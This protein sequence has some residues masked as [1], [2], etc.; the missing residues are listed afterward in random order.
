L[1]LDDCATGRLVASLTLSGSDPP[2]EVELRSMARKS[3]RGRKEIFAVIRTRR[4]GEEVRRRL[5]DGRGYAIRVSGGLSTAR[6]WTGV[7]GAPGDALR[8]RPCSVARPVPGRSGSSERR[9]RCL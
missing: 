6:A 8:D 9:P 1:R 5:E 7:R 3:G 2:A 4:S